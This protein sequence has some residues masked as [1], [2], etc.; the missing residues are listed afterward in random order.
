MMTPPAK[1]IATT[2]VPCGIS[3][4]DG[5]SIPAP[6]SWWGATR[7]STSANDGPGSTSGVK[8][9]SALDSDIGAGAYR[10]VSGR[11]R[12]NAP[13]HERRRCR[14]CSSGR[15]P[16]PSTRPLRALMRDSLLPALLHVGA[17]ELLGVVLEDGVD[18]IEEVVD[19]FL[20]LL[21]AIRGCRDLFVGDFLAL[22]GSRLLFAF[23]FSHDRPPAPPS[24]RRQSLDELSGCRYLIEQFGDVLL[25]TTR[26]L[27]HR[28]PSQRINSDVEHETVPVRGHN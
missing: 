4:V 9:G 5:P 6:G 26:G 28:D 18:F 10:R 19:V 1:R 16:S 12:T 24:A 25:A 15:R 2:V 22:L 23:P 20:Q 14:S 7:R 3:S 13:S 11:E 8:S 27:H 21:A 17:N